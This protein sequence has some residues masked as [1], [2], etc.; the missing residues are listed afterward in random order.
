MRQRRMNVP[1]R[2]QFLAVFAAMLLLTLLPQQ[3][4][5]THVDDTYMYQ[6]MLNGSNSIRIQAPVY[7]MD[8]AD[9]WVTDG[10]LKVTWTDNSGK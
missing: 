4:A 3:A 10:N 6:V 2:G 9:C 8:G 7:D 1:G 5:A